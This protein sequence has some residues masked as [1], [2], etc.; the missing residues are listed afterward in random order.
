MGDMIRRVSFVLLLAA[1][2]SFFLPFARFEFPMMGA[3]AFS[4]AGVAA[5]LAGPVKPQA[6]RK[7]DGKFAIDVRS[8][9]EMMRSD[10]GVAVFR[11]DPLYWLIPAGLA[12][13]VLAY[14]LLIFI[15]LGLWLEMPRFVSRV[16]ATCFFLTLP[17]AAGVLLLDHLLQT[18]LNASIGRLDNNPFADLAKNFM[19]GIRIEPAPAIYALGAMALLIALINRASPQQGSSYR[20]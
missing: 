19:Q 20:K 9:Q 13:G 10:D 8:V 16:A 5:G 14:V 18:I 15:A 6:Q 12:C 3:Q 7:A 2:V 1:G 17:W 11:S 4:A